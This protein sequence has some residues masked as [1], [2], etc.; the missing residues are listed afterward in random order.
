MKHARKSCADRVKNAVQNQPTRRQIKR[1]ERFAK[2]RMEKKA[3]RQLANDNV[4]HQQQHQQHD[5]P[6]TQHEQPQQNAVKQINASPVPNPQQECV[7]WNDQP[8]VIVVQVN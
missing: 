6:S 1:K 7:K 4:Q 2:Y 5:K 8:N 3:Q